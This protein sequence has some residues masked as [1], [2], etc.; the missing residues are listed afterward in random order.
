MIFLLYGDKKCCVWD[1]TSVK[2]CDAM[3]PKKD[4][5]EFEEFES[6]SPTECTGLLARGPEN[7]FE[8]ESCFD[9]MTFSPKDFESE[10][11]S[12]KP[13]GKK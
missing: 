6:A 1:N 8:R 5:D 10:V 4:G 13:A 9:V 3:E 11:N 2:G 7:E 12:E